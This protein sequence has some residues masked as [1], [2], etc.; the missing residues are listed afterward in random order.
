MQKIN[1]TIPVHRNIYGIRECEGLRDFACSKPELHHDNSSTE[2]WF[3]HVQRVQQHDEGFSESES[4]F[5]QRQ[6]LHFILQ[7]VESRQLCGGLVRQF[8]SSING[9]WKSIE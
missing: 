7:S 5:T 9:G 8:E 3:L 4:F 2:L 1:L 6:P